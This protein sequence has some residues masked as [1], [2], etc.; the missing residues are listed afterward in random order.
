MKSGLLLNN[1]GKGRYL[2][3]DSI[4]YVIKYDLREG[5]HK[6][7]LSQLISW[8]A[9]GAP[10]WNGAEGVIDAFK[11]VQILHTRKG[12]H[13]R[14]IDQEL[15]DFSEEE[16]E[17]I[18]ESGADVDAIARKMAREFFEE[19]VQVLYAVHSRD[20][21]NRDIHVHFAVNTVS[22]RTGK[23]RRENKTDTR[24]RSWKMN[25]IVKEE[26]EKSLRQKS[27]YN[28]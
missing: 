15:Y 6:E 24:N 3:E 19:G 12:A 17:A 20:E 22:Y 2:N 14:Y 21:H 26:V 27:V 10:E 1:A 7:N 8:G 5:K 13:G 18:Q 28:A 11:T 4:M 16:L 25:E 9:L 23:K